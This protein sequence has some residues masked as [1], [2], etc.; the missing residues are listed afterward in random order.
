MSLPG[1]PLATL[2]PMVPTIAHLRIGDHLGGFAQD[3]G[4][5]GQEAVDD[6][7]ALGGHRA[8]HDLAALEA[9]AFQLGD[10]G[11][12]DEMGRHGE[13]QLHHRNEAVAAGDDAGVGI[14]PAEQGDRVREAGGAMILEGSGD[15]VVLPV[16]KAR[17]RRRADSRSRA[18]QRRI[19][20]AAQSIADEPRARKGADGGRSARNASESLTHFMAEASFFSRRARRS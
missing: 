2:P 20:C 4:M 3:R 7:L 6:D 18:A 9:D 15:Q 8:D 5:L 17:A 12:V 14:Q 11:E 19:V 16:G 13:A 10:A 1:S